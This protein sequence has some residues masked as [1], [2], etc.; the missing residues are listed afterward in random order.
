[1]RATPKGLSIRM[2][3]LH[4]VFWRT[5]AY[6]RHLLVYDATTGRLHRMTNRS[7]AANYLARSRPAFQCAPQ[8]SFAWGFDPSSRWSLP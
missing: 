5:Y 3:F 4:H 8:R 2:T 7:Q 1:M 6:G